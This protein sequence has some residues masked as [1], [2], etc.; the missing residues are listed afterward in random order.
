[1]KEL[2]EKSL[3]GIYENNDF[4]RKL[5][6]VGKKYDYRSGHPVTD[7]ILHQLKSEIDYMVEKNVEYLNDENKKKG[8]NLTVTPSEAEYIR[9]KTVSDMVSAMSRYLKPSDKLIEVKKIG[10]RAGSIEISI[11]IERDGKSHSLL[12]DMI[13]AGGHSIQTLHYRYLT[14]TN[15]PSLNVSEFEKKYK[16][17]LAKLSKAEKILLEI[18]RL[19]KYINHANETIK[20]AQSLTEDDIV[21]KEIVFPL[22]SPYVD[23][24]YNKL[25]WSDVLSRGNSKN[26]EDSEEKFNEWKNQQRKENIERF[27]RRDIQNQQNQ[28]IDW[29]KYKLK[30]E[31]KLRQL[32]DN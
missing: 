11:S 32:N 20:R 26:F 7:Q 29:V 31:T 5:H 23:S 27:Y 12:T 18:K 21:N 19:D 10:S 15:L 6:R 2:I 16:A 30:E 24:W 4:N 3:T 13:T 22:D 17:E 14:K 28:I 8:I 1:M 25:T 9:I